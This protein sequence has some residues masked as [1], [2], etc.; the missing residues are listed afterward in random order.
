MVIP[1]ESEEPLWLVCNT[2]T[3]IT[4]ETAT[5]ELAVAAVVLAALGKLEFLQQLQV[6]VELV[7]HLTGQELLSG[8]LVVAEA[9]TA[10]HH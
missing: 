6:M 10:L 3:E 8:L 5:L 7:F 9:E 4:L 1:S 2:I